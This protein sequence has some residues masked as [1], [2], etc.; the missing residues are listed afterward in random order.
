MASEWL[1]RFVGVLISLVFAY[2][3]GLSEWYAAQDGT[4]KRFVM[5]AA[6]AVACVAIFGASCAGWTDQVACTQQ[7]ASGLFRIA[8]D[9]VM[10]NQA[11]YLL[12]PKRE[13]EVSQ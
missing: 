1:S 3:P 6:L 9:V 7:G 4:R 13:T 2:V 10:A 8:F 12:T 5:L 11:T